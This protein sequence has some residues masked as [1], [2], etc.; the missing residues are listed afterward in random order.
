MRFFVLIIVCLLSF[1]LRAQGGF[2]V[3]HYLPGSTNS[4][5]KD[6]FETSPGN[7][8]A[9]GIT[10]DTINGLNTN[11]LTVMKLDAQ[12]QILLVKKY[13]TKNLE[14][15]NNNLTRR[16]FYQDGNFI[17]LTCCLRD[18]N[19]KYIG[20]LVKFDSNGDT[21]WQKIYR[22]PAED[23][24]PQMVTASVDGGFL[25]TGFFQNWANSTSP[26]LLIKTNSNGQELWRKRIHKLGDDVSDGKAIIQDSA[27]KKIV[28]VG[29]QYVGSPQSSSMKDNVLVLD[30]LGNTIWRRYY[31][32]FGGHLL[33][34]IQTKDKHIVAVG[35]AFKSQMIGS[36]L[37]QRSFIV[38]I[39]LNAS[40]TASPLWFNT[41]FDVLALE[42]GFSCIRELPNGDLIVAGYIDS[43]SNY[44]RN[45]HT[46]I[47]KF[48]TNGSLKSKIY[49]N[50]KINDSSLDNN[51]VVSSLNLT[52]D[53]GWVASIFQ[54]NSPSPNPLFYV[55]YDSTGCD[56]I[57]AYCANPVGQ[58][59]LGAG[60]LTGLA[61]GIKVFP[62]PSSDKF[63]LSIPP[64][65]NLP[66]KLELRD[67]LGSLILSEQFFSTN[68]T[69]EL[70]L[71][72]FSNG[73]YLLNI[74]NS[75]N[76]IIFKGKL[77]KKE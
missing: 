76:E 35:V 56:S 27:T 13:G 52:S 51:Q 12:G 22:D 59:E 38:K 58:N 42:N 68:N 8:V 39:D 32:G 44:P 71:K 43:T 63:S 77:I 11:R 37:G 16:A 62:N 9:C 48:N 5:T 15:L 2:K 6:I 10:I 69:I 74:S 18:S 30:S 26:C 66:L 50:Y 31:S 65:L 1:T 19:N 14:Y 29:Y 7:Y 40:P 33:D 61:A 41:N 34:A 72:N 4:V 28:I 23:L 20:A 53:G 46:R 64:N 54:I 25:I 3:R 60:A 55:K 47:V 49:Y 73:I 17:Y 36:T 75:K 24:I 57:V 45:I 70:S 67:V 21:L